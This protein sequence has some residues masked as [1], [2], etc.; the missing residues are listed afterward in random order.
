MGH[1]QNEMQN[2]NNLFF[3]AND[4]SV[5][6]KGSTPLISTKSKSLALQGF[7]DFYYVHQ[8]FF[9]PSLLYFCMPTH[10]FVCPIIHLMQNVNAK[11]KCKMTPAL[12]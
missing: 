7:F 8:W 3:C 12:Y 2:E 5:L 10:T 6:Q 4:F 1:M 9:S 11:R